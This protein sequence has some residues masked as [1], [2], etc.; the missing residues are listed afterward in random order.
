MSDA[1]TM[2]SAVAELISTLREAPQRVG[3]KTRIDRIRILEELKSAAAAAQVRESVAFAESQLAEQR[4]AGVKAREL[5]RGIASQVGLARRITPHRASRELGWASVLTAELPNTYQALRDGKISEWR[6]VLVARETVWLSAEHRAQV[7]AELAPRLE[8]FN[9]KQVENEAR[10]IGYRL[11]PQ[12]FV[13]RRA[14]AEQDRRVWI[15]PA[16]DTMVRLTALLPVAQGVAAYAA[17]S[18]AADTTVAVGDERGRGQIMAD[19]LVERLTGQAAATDVPVAVNLVMTDQALL[20]GGDEPA[21]VEGYGPVPAQAARDLIT[22]PS[23]ETPMWIR[24]LFT[25]PKTGHLVAM[26]STQRCFTGGQRRFIALRDQYQCRTTWC[27]APLRH[28]DHVH[29]HDDGGPTAVLNG[30]G[31]CEACNHAKQAPG[32]TTRV[33]ENDD[34]VHEVETITPTGHRYRSRAPDPPSS[35]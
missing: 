33:I 1:D 19:T 15:R 27:A 2:V 20:D 35:N 9:D 5:G 11:D 8:A 10:R 24:R 21:L 31:N 3:D 6:A 23:D 34:G 4:A 16:P 14:A 25:A 7:D 26:E 17:L 22:T 12:T 30:R 29:P 28:A 13:A 18:R 32:W